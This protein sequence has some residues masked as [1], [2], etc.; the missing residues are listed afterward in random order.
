MLDYPQRPEGAYNER[1]EQLY[2]ELWK[3]VEQINLLEER[4]QKLEA[5]A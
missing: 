3:A 4:V 2:E 5:Q 1:F